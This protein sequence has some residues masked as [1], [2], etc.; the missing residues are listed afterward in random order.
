VEAPDIRQC[1]VKDGGF[2]DPFL[3]R[4]GGG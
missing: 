3:H 1:L 4:G 2:F